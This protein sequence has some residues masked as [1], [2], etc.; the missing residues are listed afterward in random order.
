MKITI[1]E[2]FKKLNLKRNEILYIVNNDTEHE[3]KIPNILRNL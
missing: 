1:E 3:F 2:L